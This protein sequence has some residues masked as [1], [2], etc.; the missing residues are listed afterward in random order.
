M[1]TNLDFGQFPDASG[2]FGVHGGRFVSETL[3]KALEELEQIY[4]TA[5]AD[6]EFWNEFMADLTDYVGR[7][8]PLY[9][10]ERLSREIGGAKIFFKREDLNHTG[11]HKV[12]NT[13]GQALL[14]KMVGKSA[15]LRRREQV[16]MASLPP[17]LR[18]VLVLSVWFIW[19]QMMSSAKK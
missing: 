15:S 12:N 1:T 3:M 8:T 9:F 18:R 17:R 19:V 16:S 10:A 11:A 5:K 7:P 6:P 4:K 13:I 14:A 2:H